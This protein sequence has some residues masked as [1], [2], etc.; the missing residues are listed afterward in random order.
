MH[1]N[2]AAARLRWAAARQI[3]LDPAQDEQKCRAWRIHFYDAVTARQAASVCEDGSD[4]QRDLNLFDSEIDIQGAASSWRRA[5]RMARARASRGG[6]ART[7][8]IIA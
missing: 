5:G 8:N 4:R 1:R 2:L 3:R 7:C 6:C